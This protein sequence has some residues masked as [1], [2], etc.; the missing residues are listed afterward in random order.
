MSL[1]DSITS[2]VNATVTVT[3]HAEGVYT[4]G[5]YAPGAASTFTCD[6][7]MQPA[8][9]LNRVIGG[10]DLHAGVEG[11][12]TT[13]VLNFFTV[14]EIKTRTPTTDPDVITYRGASWTVARVEPW[15]LISDT[16]YRVLITKQTGGAS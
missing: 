16:Y 8:F 9:G 3:R 1:L 4:N 12:S 14:T 6:V 15:T 5:I 2:L 11:Q 13:D 10:A 7:V